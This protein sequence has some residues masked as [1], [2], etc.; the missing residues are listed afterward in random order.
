M[1]LQATINRQV[2]NY[3]KWDFIIFLSLTLLSVLNGQTT[4]FYLIYFFWWSA[5]IQLVVDFSYRNWNKNAI[6]EK[7]G[8]FEFGSLFLMGIYWVFIVVFFGFIAGSNHQD[9]IYANMQVLFFQNWFFN[10]NLIFIL[11]ERV[12]LH[13][14]QQPV[15]IYLGAFSPNAIVL[16]ISIIVGG[17][18]MFFVV[19]NYP[20]TFTPENRWGSLLIVLPFLF[21]KMLMQKLTASDNV[22]PK[23]NNS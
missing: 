9:I 12:F 23:P 5:L 20:E 17:V 18:V 11:I 13:K 10:G 16:H 21:L 22:M 3:R 4:V 8:Q 19:K 14:T 1:S 7:D 2:K 15:R 6:R